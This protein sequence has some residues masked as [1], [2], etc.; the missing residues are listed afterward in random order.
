MTRISICIATY[1]GERYIKEQIDS[2]LEQIDDNDEIIISDDNS[3]DNTVNIIKKYSDRRIKI[4]FNSGK[5]GYT[6]NFEN[7]L[8]MA[9][10][11]YIFLSDQD[12][13]WVPEKVQVCL[14]YLENGF[15]MVISD[16]LIGDENIN[17]IENSYFEFRNAKEGFWNNIIKAS[18]LGCC[19]AF[20]R[21]I[22]TRAL[23]FPKNSKYLPHDLWLGLIGY[24]FFN[25]SK[26]NNKLII[27]RR[28]N[29]NASNGGGKSK[30]SFII[31]IYIRIYAIINIL[32]RSI[33]L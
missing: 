24:A 21:K 2:I 4:Y 23:P 5:K 9:R 19:M 32:K 10:G 15:D 18:Y 13:K 29:E 8:K 17:I 3:T 12:D 22:L 27:Y 14:K 31:K 6:S 7:A 33:K 28:H 11:K 1:N 20:N 26:I 25:V 16:C 30:N